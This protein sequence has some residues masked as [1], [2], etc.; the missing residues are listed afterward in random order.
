MEEIW[1][2]TRYHIQDDEKYI[3][4]GRQICA[5]VDYEDI[6]VRELSNMSVGIQAILP[7]MEGGNPGELRKG[8]LEDDLE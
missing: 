6:P 5:L 1:P 7:N 2:G 4:A 3:S 8:P